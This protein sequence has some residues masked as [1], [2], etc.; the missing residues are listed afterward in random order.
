MLSGG[1]GR[2]A[3]DRAFLELFGIENAFGSV[4]PDGN[5][6]PA[7]FRE[8]FATH[9]LLVADGSPAFAATARLYESHLQREMESSSEAHLMP[10]VLPLLDHLAAN[11]DFA[12][13]LL[14][15]NFEATARIKLEHFGL[16]RFFSFGAFGSDHGI[17]E[18][19]VPIAVRRAEALL[20][21]SIGLGPQVVVVGDTPRDVECALAHGATAIGVAASR[22]S[23][24]DLETAGARHAL[25]TLEDIPAFLAA[26]NASSS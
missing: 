6:D 15:G 18:H 2:R 26:I 17:R 16:N 23:V 24:D 5:T 10:G 3:I 25:R 1:A 19:L 9:D 7:I 12:L 11:D 14:T 20:E 22:Y 4:V 13:G 21:R 8:I